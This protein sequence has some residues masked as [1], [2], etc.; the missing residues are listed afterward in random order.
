MKTEY[1]HYF[2]VA[3]RAKSFSKAA[4]ELHISQQG[5]SRVIKILE[6]EYGCLLFKRGNWQ[7]QLT[8]AGQTLQA[9]AESV[10]D[11]YEHLERVMDGQ[12]LSPQT[13]SDVE[14]VTI[15]MTLNTMH[16]F[17][18]LF[19]SALSASFPT[20]RFS[21]REVDPSNLHEMVRQ[22]HDGN[23]LFF[24]SIPEYRLQQFTADEEMHFRPLLDTELDC[25]VGRNSALAA[26]SSFDWKD[27][28]Q[29]EL[30]LKKDPAMIELLRHKGAIHSTSDFEYWSTDSKFL[31][32]ILN[33]Q[34]AVSFS[35]SFLGLYPELDSFPHI[36]IDDTVKTP[37]GFLMK[38]GDE[39]SEI[40]QAVI[41]FVERFSSIN[42]PKGLFSSAEK[43]AGVWAPVSLSDGSGEKQVGAVS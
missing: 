6:K 38:G 5:L 4:E 15:S 11:A 20:A 21:V 22:D 17:Y 14:K 43:V 7:V 26:I 36:P 40:A 37:V 30:V 41:N 24:I 16:N 3:S 25:I 23:D 12:G 42:Y 10:L 9:L 39:L 8:Q 32:A 13:D 34:D 1:L 28:E 35:T 2:C 33:A 31:E 29:Y 19:A 18:P 27:I